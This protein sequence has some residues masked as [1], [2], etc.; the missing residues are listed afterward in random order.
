MK[1]IQSITAEK[2][3]RHRFSDYKPIRR[4]GAANS[5]VG[6]PIRPNVKLFRSLMHVIITCKYKKEWMK[7][8]GQIL[9]IHSQDIE[10]NQFLTSIKGRNSFA[11]LRKMTLYNSNIRSLSMTMG[12]QNLVE[13]CPSIFKILNKPEDQWSCTRSPE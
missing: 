5:A 8:V 3:R 10:Q 7:K 9:S 4:S 2:N 6:G 1:R 13:F 11:N 12:I